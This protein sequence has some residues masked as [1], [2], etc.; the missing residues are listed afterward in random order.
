M[1][2]MERQRAGKTGGIMI[3]MYNAGRHGDG[4]TT[5][6]RQ[7]LT[8]QLHSTLMNVDGN[9]VCGVNVVMGSLVHIICSSICSSKIPN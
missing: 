9:G 5:Q 7:V 1:A 2:G 4:C 8:E 6:R 3:S